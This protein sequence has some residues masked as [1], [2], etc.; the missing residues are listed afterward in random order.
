MPEQD[1]AQVNHREKVVCVVLVAHDKPTEVLEPGEEALD[2][3]PAAIP[4]ERAAIL[5]S[6]A[7]APVRS[8]QLDVRFLG[9]FLVKR[10]GVVRAVSDESLRRRG[11]EAAVEGGADESDL[12]WRSTLDANG[13]RKTRAVCHC[14]DLGPFATL[15]FADTEPPFFAGAKVASMKA[16]ERSSPPLRSRSSA[17]VRTMRSSVPSR[18]HC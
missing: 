9:E 7:V 4:P 8:N 16:S 2:L 15:G 13:D 3:P 14:H 10:I 17:S 11:E 12:M 1:A 5:G 6:R 18:A